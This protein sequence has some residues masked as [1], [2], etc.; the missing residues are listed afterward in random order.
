MGWLSRTFGRQRR[1]GADATGA[2]GGR[3]QA[4]ARLA[5]DVAHLRDFA[6]TRRGVEFY[7]EPENDGFDTTLVAVAYDGE[8]TRRRVASPSAAGK[9]ARSLS[10]PVYEAGV[11]GYPRRMKEWS[12]AHPERKLRPR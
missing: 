1:S 9:L 3:G 12:R 2:G 4:A 8:W 7:L 6:T 5:E 10:L 11:T